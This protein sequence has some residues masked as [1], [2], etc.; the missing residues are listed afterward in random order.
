MIVLAGAATQVAGASLPSSTCFGRHDPGTGTLHY[1]DATLAVTSPKRSPDQ[2]LREVRARFGDATFIK[3]AGFGGIPP[4]THQHTG[5]FGKTRPPKD[6][7]WLYV[8]DP[9]ANTR[10]FATNRHPPADAIAEYTKAQ[11]ESYLFAGAVRDEL[12]VHGDRPFVGWTLNN[13]LTGGLSVSDAAQPFAQRFPNLSN[14]RLLKNLRS[15]SKRYR[16]SV[17]S[18]SYLHPLQLVPVVVLHAH[19][20]AVFAGN[21]RVIFNS[22]RIMGTRPPFEGWF[23]EVR[24]DRGPFLIWSGALRGIAMGSFWC[25]PRVATCPQGDM[26]RVPKKR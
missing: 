10:Q 1:T 21:Q 12:C 3:G 8:S 14:A 5:Y 6:G 19:D 25:A 4:I 20:A 2:L 22:F 7:I 16:F 15:L 13:R 11:L 26:L 9:L 18:V 23:V 24:D 17:E